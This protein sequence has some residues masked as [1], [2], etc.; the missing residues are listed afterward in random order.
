MGEDLAHPQHI[1]L[2]MPPL[3]VKWNETRDDDTDLFPLF[4][5]CAVPADRRLLPCPR[6]SHD[7]T[8]AY[9]AL[10]GRFQCLSSVAIA[11][12][13]KFMQFAPTMFERCTRLISRT[14]EDISIYEQAKQVR[15]ARTLSEYDAVGCTD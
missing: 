3:V 11:L 13:D 7:A 8:F 14:L 12:G 4:E 5:V 1:A 10:D 6:A 2:L 9:V 15:P